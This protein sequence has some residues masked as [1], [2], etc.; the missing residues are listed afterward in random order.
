M[1]ASAKSLT[2]VNL[3]AGHVSVSVFSASA[4]SLV[5]ERFVV[6]DLAPGIAGDDEWL[7][8]AMEALRGLVA[9]QELRGTATVIVPGFLLLSKPLKVA[10][11]EKERQAQIIAFEAQNAIPYPLSEVVWGSQV[12][13]SDGVEAEVLLFALRSEIAGRI[14][15]QVSAAGLRP[16]VIQAGPLLDGQA[17]RLLSGDAAEEVLVVNIGS[18]TTN[19]TFLG[20]SGMSVQTATL[21]GNTVTQGLSDN[22]GNAFVNAEALKVGFFSGVIQL[23]ESDPQV[24]ALVANAQAFSRRL[25][26][27]INRRLINLRRGN[28]ARQPARVLLAGRAAL[29]PGLREQLA[30]T[31]RVPVET[32]DPLAAVSLGANVN[33]A[34]VEA[35]RSQLSEPVGEAARL[36][37]ADPAGVNLIPAPIAAELAFNSRKPVL[38]AAAALL[39]LSPLPAGWFFSAAADAAATRLEEV[40]GRETSLGS[41]RAELLAAR[42]QSAALAAVNAQLDSVVMTRANWNDFLVELQTQILAA[43]HTWVEELRTRRDQPPAPTVAEGE[44]PAPAPAPQ[45]RVILSVRLLLPEVAAGKDAVIN[46]E[47]F[48]R[49]QRELVEALRKNSFVQ[50]VPDADIRADTSQPNLPRLT[51]TLVLKPEKSL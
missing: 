47:V 16:T 4:G 15:Q 11:V 1:S 39:A 25:A 7:A 40:R 49:R 32:L 44:P 18:R 6:Q 26:Q 37:L 24:A 48:R 42:E 9:Q 29:L 2:V 14:A 19:L 10:Q 33:P 28:A 8:A 3:A 12:L 50:S 20:P 13:A 5:L 23:P 41:R 34:Y 46:S 31:L 17:W 38:L 43:R 35:C 22:T 45:T 36:L 21:G 27:D 51:L 30:E